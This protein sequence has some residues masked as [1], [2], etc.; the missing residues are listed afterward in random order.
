MGVPYYVR[1]ITDWSHSSVR[2]LL[3]GDDPWLTSQEARALRSDWA[4]FLR[5]YPSADD[6]VRLRRH[7]RAA[8][9]PASARG[10]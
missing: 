7:L 1:D 8:P 10:A 5:E 3:G 9:A 2:A 4:S 6:L